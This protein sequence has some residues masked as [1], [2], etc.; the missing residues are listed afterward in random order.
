MREK[1]NVDFQW[2][3]L[4]SYFK[5]LDILYN[6]NNTKYK[7]CSMEYEKDKKKNRPTILNQ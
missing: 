2:Y 4:D 7:K 3:Y 5:I 6:H 1:I